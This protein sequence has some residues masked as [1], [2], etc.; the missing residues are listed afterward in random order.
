MTETTVISQTDARGVT[1]IVLNRADK[2][3]AFNDQIIVELTEAIEAA[4]NNPQCRVVIIAGE[5][6]HFSAGADLVYMKQTAALSEQENVDDAHRLARLM[7]VLDLI[8]KPTI[9]RVQGAAYGGALGLIT[10]CDIAVGTDTSRYCLSEARLGITPAAIGPYVV[11]A[12]GP[13]QARRYFLSSEEIPADKALEIGLI[14]EQVPEDQLDARI[15]ELTVTLLRN[16]PVAM[17]A[18]KALVA[19]VT[20]GHISADTIDYTARLIARLRTGDEGQEG[21]GAFFSK[22]TPGWVPES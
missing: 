2:R 4:S 6:K 12:M 17:A 20:G 5:G 18:G 16:G 11:R 19:E 1:R 3:N 15:E 9:C 22:R 21:L 7:Q 10:A 8:D 13:R 14:H